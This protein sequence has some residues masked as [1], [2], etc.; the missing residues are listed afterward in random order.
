M[1]LREYVIERYNHAARYAREPIAGRIEVGFGLFDAPSPPAGYGKSSIEI[2][3]TLRSAGDL[4][5]H[6][7]LASREGI[8]ALPYRTIV[9]TIEL[10]GFQRHVTPK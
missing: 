1:I 4:P 6:A 9:K 8:P 7:R 10:R 3:P 2:P 5:G